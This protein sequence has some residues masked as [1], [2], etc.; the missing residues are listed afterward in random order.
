MMSGL[1]CQLDKMQ[2]VRRYVEG[3]ACLG[4]STVS[5]QGPMVVFNDCFGDTRGTVR[6][7]ALR[8]RTNAASAKEQK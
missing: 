7:N 8:I 1:F 6:V 5:E 2:V 3:G 4:E